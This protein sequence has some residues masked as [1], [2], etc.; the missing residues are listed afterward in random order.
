MQGELQIPT[1]RTLYFSVALKL[2]QLYLRIL[3]IVWSGALLDIEG[4]R[5]IIALSRTP[6][7]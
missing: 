6:L 7:H 5:R 3:D 1:V 4:R 2:A